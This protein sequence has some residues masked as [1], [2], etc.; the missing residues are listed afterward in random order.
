MQTSELKL[1]PSTAVA[2]TS[3]T[4]FWNVAGVLAWNERIDIFVALLLMY[5]YHYVHRDNELCVSA[6]AWHACLRVCAVYVFMFFI[7][8]DD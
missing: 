6:F 5:A 1:F 2:Q 7:V 8:D 4:N 3:N